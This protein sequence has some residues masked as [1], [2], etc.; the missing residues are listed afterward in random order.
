MRLWRAIVLFAFAA[1]FC[2]VAAAQSWTQVGPEGGDVRSL[3]ADPR[4]ARVLYLGTS[5]GHIFTSRD[6]AG[7]WRQLGRVGTPDTVARQLE[8]LRARLP[9]RWLFAWTYNGLVPH[10]KLMHS[11]ERFA[12]AVL[13]RVSGSAT[14]PQRVGRSDARQSS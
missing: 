10:A 4:D 6:S 1:L 9:V 11:I 12:R 8:D 2:V 7:H 13:P 3:V 5:D 14:A